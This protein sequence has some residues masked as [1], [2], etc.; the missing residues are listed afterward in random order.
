MP[1]FYTLYFHKCKQNLSMCV[2]D[3]GSLTT[4]LSGLLQISILGISRIS[5]LCQEQTISCGWIEVILLN[6]VF[7][8]KANINENNFANMT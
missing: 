3:W 6:F 4:I 1:Q 8:V 5:H 7:I 2:T